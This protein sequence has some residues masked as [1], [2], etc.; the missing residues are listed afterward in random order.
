MKIRFSYRLERSLLSDLLRFVR[1]RVVTSDVLNAPMKNWILGSRVFSM[2]ETR[3]ERHRHDPIVTVII[4]SA[5]GSQP[6]RAGSHRFLRARAMQRNK[7]SAF[8]F[9][10]GRWKTRFPDRTR[11]TETG[12]CHFSARRSASARPRKNRNNRP[13]AHARARGP[14]IGL[15]SFFVRVLARGPTEIATLRATG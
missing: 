11:E 1:G 10:D 5:C 3:A 12:P 15:S 8:V 9:V 13:V 6:W 4:L 14:W 2:E 7:L